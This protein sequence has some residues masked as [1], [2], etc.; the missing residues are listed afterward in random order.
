MRCWT[1]ATIARGP[2]PTER[3]RDVRVAEIPPPPRCLQV[4]DRRNS[5]FRDRR[6]ETVFN[7]ARKLGLDESR[8]FK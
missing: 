7:D 8:G 2:L 5:G 6:G 1:R 4:R 3:R